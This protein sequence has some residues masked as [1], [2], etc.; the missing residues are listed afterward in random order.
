MVHDLNFSCNY[1][2]VDEFYSKTVSKTELFV[3]HLNVW[4]LKSKLE[5]FLNFLDG[6]NTKPHVIILS[7]TWFEPNSEIELDFYESTHT[8]RSSRAGGISIYVHKGISFEPLSEACGIN[9]YME[10][11]AVLLK[12]NSGDKLNVIGVYRPPNPDSRINELHSYLYNCVLSKIKNRSPILIGGDLN[13]NILCTSGPVA[14]V[15]NNFYSKSYV[16]LINVA[17]RVTLDESSATCLDHFWAKMQF[18]SESGVIKKRISDHYPI[19]TLLDVGC[20]IDDKLIVTFRDHSQRKLDFFKNEVENSLTQNTWYCDNDIDNS[21][22]RFLKTLYGLYDKCC[23]L[24]SKC[25][26]RN[27][28][29]KPWLNPDVKLILN[30]KHCLYRRYRRNE[31]DLEFYKSFCSVVKKCIKAA[32]EK[33][34]HQKFSDCKFDSNQTWRCINSLLRPGRKNKCNYKIKL[35]DGS[36]TTDNAQV[37]NV[38]NEYFTSIGKKLDESIPAVDGNALDFMNERLEP[39]FF[40]RNCTTDEVFNLIVS[41]PNKRGS[42]STIP[43]FVLKY[44]AEAISEPIALLFDDSIAQGKFPEALKTARVTP[45]FK[46]G[47][48]HECSNFRPI[49]ILNFLSKIFEKLM[50]T[51]LNK[52]IKKFSILNDNQFGFRS[53]LNTTDA[54]LDFLSAAQNSLNDRSHMLVLYLDFSKAF[55]TVNHEILLSKLDHIGIRGT[56]KSWFRSYLIG[57]S[58]TVGINGVDSSKL[59]I[60]SGVP[61][62]SILGPLLFIIYIND[63]RNSCGRLNCVQFADDTTLFLSGNIADSVGE[64]FNLQ[65]T[66]IDTWLKLN[67]LSLNITKSFYMSFPCRDNYMITLRN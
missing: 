30:K 4:S 28:Q 2:E 64:E 63:M 5:E 25:F 23:P 27:S 31:I 66:V 13:V 16:P 59:P 53:G 29:S 49:S 21:C 34:Y 65:L 8:S 19:F 60:L 12:L 11:C 55:D 57:R 45:I 24:R 39:S 37:A 36:L 6:M 14:E 40:V 56:V 46:S 51:R 58:Q 42:L 50:V 62:G 20:S 48:R 18:P 47:V 3:L 41:M 67:R 44:I 33:Y 52:F 54:L 35:Q 38:F 15:I 61:Q 26:S 7:E 10:T 17:T 22:E 43:I 32:K 9:E 1:Y